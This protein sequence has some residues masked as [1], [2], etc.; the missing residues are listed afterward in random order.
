MNKSNNS[1][2]EMVGAEALTQ[3]LK[4]DQKVWGGR[5]KKQKQSL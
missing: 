1:D 2:S 4:V 3:G 5:K